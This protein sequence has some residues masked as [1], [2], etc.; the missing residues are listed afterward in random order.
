MSSPYGSH[1]WHKQRT[2]NAHVAQTT[3]KQ[4]TRGISRTNNAHVASGC[5]CMPAAAV[6]SVGCGTMVCV[7]R[8]Y[9][10]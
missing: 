1:T 6:G 10:G 9:E 8:A 3:H 7:A 4:R 2:N 5:M